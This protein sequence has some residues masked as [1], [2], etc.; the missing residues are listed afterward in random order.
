MY[1]TYL[2]LDIDGVL[3]SKDWYRYYW[4]NDFVKTHPEYDYDIDFRA[5]KRLN[6]IINKTNA[7]VV[8]SSTWRMNLKDTNRR[9]KKAGATFDTVN[10]IDGYEYS[11]NDEHPTRGELI[12]K[13]INEFPCNNYVIIDDDE[14]MTDNQ[15]P[16]FIHTDSWVGL[17]DKDVDKAI[18]IL[19][20]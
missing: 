6:K 1:K 15:L 14:D 12:E 17:T 3:N 11:V 19:R 18:N 10:K 9:L 7:T 2:F 13:Y 16:H 4:N 20:T 8:L 5:V